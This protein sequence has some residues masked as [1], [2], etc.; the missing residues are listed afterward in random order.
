MGYKRMN[1]TNIVLSESSH[2]EYLLSDSIFIKF[3]KQVKLSH[4]VERDA[5]LSRK[6]IKKERKQLPLR[7]R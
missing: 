2:M 4:R 1:I 5:Y 6:A 3:K 7:A